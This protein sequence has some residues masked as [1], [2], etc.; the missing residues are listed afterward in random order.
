MFTSPEGAVAIAGNAI[1]AARRVD[2]APAP[3]FGLAVLG[4]VGS[5]TA[6]ALRAAGPGFEATDNVGLNG[7]EGLYQRRVAGTPSSVTGTS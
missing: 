6:E 4:K 2:L 3:T 1:P 5:A 7:L